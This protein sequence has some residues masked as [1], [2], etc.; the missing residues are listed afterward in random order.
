MN[1]RLTVILLLAIAIIASSLWSLRRHTPVEVVEATRGDVTEIIVAT[2]K[3]KA[4]LDSEIGSDVA[5]VVDQVFISEGKQVLPGQVLVTLKSDD[6]VSRL[7]QAE[8][9]LFTA[10]QELLRVS[11][12]AL[13]EEIAKA[14]AELR[15][16]REV[17]A[18]QVKLAQERLLQ[19]QQGGRMEERDRAQANLSQAQIAQAQADADL[20]RSESL[21]AKDA[22]G[23][24]EL[25]RAQTRAKDAVAA[26]RVARESYNLSMAP[27]DE[28][29]ISSAKAQLEQAEAQYRASENI[30]QQN[31][32]ILRRTPRTELV[33]ATKAKV[34]EAIANV[35]AAKTDISRRTIRA[36]FS[37]VVVKRY[38]NPGNRIHPANVLMEIADMSD[39]EILVDTDENNLGRLKLGQ[40]ARVVSPSARELP[41][42]AKLTRIGP[43]VDSK[44]GMAPLQLKPVWLPSFCKPNMI[45]DVSLE[46]APL[47]G[48][49]ILPV[50]AV[51]EGTATA[52][53]YIIQNGRVKRQEI[54][55]LSRSPNTMAVSGVSV[56]T[57]VVKLATTVAEGQKVQPLVTKPKESD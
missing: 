3:L 4:V 44:R 45:V 13:P 52:S 37:G 25:E 16:A 2:G 55:V 54:N 7:D 8:A 35:A 42:D 21:Y 30:A 19:A 51:L 46:V 28:H 26:V 48:G 5:G 38:T 53:V 32:G 12:P 6:A 49:V 43:A 50:S 1:R 41:W 18:A 23:R 29:D 10:Q 15:Q 11:A 36:P 47:T 27:E 34:S 22:I 20:K 33:K 31:L 56:G 40:M 24:V 39:T 57:Q 17:N 9:Q 14:Q